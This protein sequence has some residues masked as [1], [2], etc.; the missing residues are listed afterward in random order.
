MLWIIGSGQ[1]DLQN[2]FPHE[3]ASIPTSL[4]QNISKS[5]LK[6]FLQVE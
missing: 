1:F 3:L 2:V 6:T 4:S 5:K